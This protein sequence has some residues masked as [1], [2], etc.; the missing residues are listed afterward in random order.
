MK[1]G[2]KIKCQLT[3]PNYAQFPLS[4]TE[5]VCVFIIAE[6]F[7]ISVARESKDLESIKDIIIVSSTK[8]VTYENKAIFRIRR[9]IWH[10]QCT[11]MARKTSALKMES[12]P[13]IHI[14]YT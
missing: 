5:C 9:Q 4:Q 7:Q 2:V 1:L 13:I 11:Y 8:I 12:F 10:Q 6:E 3:L 14:Y